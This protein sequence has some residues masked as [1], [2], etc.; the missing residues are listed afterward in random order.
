MLRLPNAGVNQRSKISTCQRRKF[1]TGFSRLMGFNTG[2]SML[3]SIRF[4]AGFQ[5]VAMIRNAV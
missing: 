5:D 2:F 1:S 3:E 4:I